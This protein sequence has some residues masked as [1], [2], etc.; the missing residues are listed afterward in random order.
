MREGGKENVLII[1]YVLDASHTLFHLI[2]TMVIYTDPYFAHEKPKVQRGYY[3]A[4][5][6]TDSE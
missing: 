6:Q 4:H 3:F 1:V 5:G 2:F